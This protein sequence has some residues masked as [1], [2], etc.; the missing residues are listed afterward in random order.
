MPHSKTWLCYHLVFATKNRHPF[1]V[2]PIERT[3]WGILWDVCRSNGLH[4]FAVGG[5]ED[6]IHILVGIPATICVADAVQ[7]IK[8]VSSLEIKRRIPQ[9]SSFSWQN[10]YTA[11][12]F[13]QRSLSRLVHYVKHQR[14]HHDGINGK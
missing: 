9:L 5:V 14:E 8:G 7:R 12:T 11:L 13:D 1:I 3:V 2:E 4:P 6:H 10:G